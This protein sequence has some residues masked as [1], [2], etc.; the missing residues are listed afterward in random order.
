MGLSNV[1]IKSFFKWFVD[2]YHHDSYFTDEEF[3]WEANTQEDVFLM[4]TDEDELILF[5]I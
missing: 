2:V 1:S 5:D 4:E 3:L